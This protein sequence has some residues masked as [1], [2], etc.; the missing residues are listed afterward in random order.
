MR[1]FPE[2][3][4][5]FPALCLAAGIAAAGYFV[6]QTLYNSEAA[7][8]TAE[9]TGLAERRVLADRAIWRIQYT[10]TGS[11]ADEIADL[12]ARSEQQKAE[13]IAVLEASGLTR[14]EIYTG[15][16]DYHRIEY[17]DDAQRLVDARRVLSGAVEV[18]T[19]RV[20]QIAP[21]RAR[22]NDLIARGFDLANNPPS[23]L[24]T[25]LNDIKPEMVREAT[26]NARL[27]AGEFARNAGVSVGRIRSARQGNFVIRDAGSDYDNT[28]RIEKDIRVVTT[29]TFYLD[30]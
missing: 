1:T 11:D 3:Y 8:T 6:G 15:V 13:I 27:A 17:R 20:Q 10:V 25:G 7:L 18:E 14:D 19:P 29:I 22:L 30:G 26:T 2:R 24:F 5:L 28:A 9:V 4:L 21:A 12:Y 23:Y 16:V